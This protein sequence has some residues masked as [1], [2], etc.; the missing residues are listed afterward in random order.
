MLISRSQL[1]M[2]SLRS[3]SSPPPPHG[4]LTAKRGIKMQLFLQFAQTVIYQMRLGVS[5]E[6]GVV[7]NCS[8]ITNSVGAMLTRRSYRRSA[9]TN[10]RDELCTNIKTR[11]KARGSFFLSFFFP[12]R[13]KSNAQYCA[14]KHTFCASRV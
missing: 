14:E 6:I 1:I 9:I 11:W 10:A 3:P 5:R 13:G 8:F 2:H 4:S 12:F 7:E